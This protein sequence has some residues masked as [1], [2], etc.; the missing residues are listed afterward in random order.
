MSSGDKVDFQM[1]PY[2]ELKS[3]TWSKDS[4][5]LFDYENQNIFTSKFQLKSNSTIYR[6]GNEVITVLKNKGNNEKNTFLTEISMNKIDNKNTFF[7]KPNCYSMEEIFYIVR[8]FKNSEGQAKGYM[9]KPGDIIKLGRNEY[10]ILECKYENLAVVSGPVNTFCIPSQ[11]KYPKYVASAEN[12]PKKTCKICFLDEENFEDGSEFFFISPCNCKGSC[13]FVHL[14][15]LK[16]WLASR[17]NPK[18]N[19]NTLSYNWKKLECEVCKQPLPKELEIGDKKFNLISINK[20]DVPYIIL[21]NVSRDKKISKGLYIVQLLPSDQIKLG[22][23]HQCDLRISDIS[24]SRLHA[25]IRFEKGQFM[26]YDNN[27]KF[28][29]LVL[30]QEPYQITNE[31]IGV[32]IGRTVI[33]LALKYSDSQHSSTSINNIKQNENSL[34]INK[35]TQSKENVKVKKDSKKKKENAMNLENNEDLDNS[36]SKIDKL[37]EEMQDE[38]E[39]DNEF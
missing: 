25:Y 31:K 14:E 15:C 4:H 7:V 20:P 30:M 32:Q 8:T 3:I 24:V 1:N 26:L 12:G 6:S 5:G 22:R 23:G 39:N 38:K 37:D 2:I 9:I 11:Y 13:E 34:T 16:G 35:K 18:A 21:E 27:S 33:S 10:N 17:L 36:I 19:N 28:G 29:T